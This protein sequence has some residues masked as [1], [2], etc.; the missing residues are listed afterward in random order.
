MAF[1]GDL[2]VRLG[3]DS[4]RFSRGVGKARSAIRSFSRFALNALAPIATVLGGRESVRAYEEQRTAIARLEQ[5]LKTTGNAAGVTSEQLQKFAAARQAVT[6]FGDEVTIQGASVLATFKNIQGQAF[7][8]TIEL[9]QDVSALMGNDLQSAMV[10][11][12]KAINDPIT[13]L[14]QLNRVGITFSKEQQE[15]IKLLQESGNLMEAQAVILDEVRS[16]FGGAAEAARSPWTALSNTFGDL[17]E[18]IGELISGGAG[19]SLVEWIDGVVQRVTQGVDVVI[20][21]RDAFYDWATTSAQN[22]NNV[23]AVILRGGQAV[24]E[25]VKKLFFGIVNFSMSWDVVK[26]AAVNFFHLAV[27]RFDW[28]TGVIGDFLGWFGRNWVQVF[29]TAIDFTLT[30][31][32]NLGENIRKIFSELW[33]VVASGFTKEFNVELNSLTEGFVNTIEE[34]FKIREFV[35]PEAK[36]DALDKF[37]AAF[38]EFEKMGKQS[39]E[40]TINPE[41]FKRTMGP[42]LGDIEREEQKQEPKKQGPTPAIGLNTKEGLETILNAMMGRSTPEDKTAKNTAS[43]DKTLKKIDRKLGTSPPVAG[44]TT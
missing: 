13:G 5:I 1:G 31:F 2:V 36:T 32:I 9:A 10:Q 29:E 11:L 25:M 17:L 34:K 23:F 6:N 38:S 8:D 35:A 18:K 20:Q 24:I 40:D 30:M 39:I 43:M 28:F 22:S 41:S 26:E 3:M 21:W 12:G 44:A 14:S 37:N 33:E 7:L 42:G 15:R 19:G 27:A 4:A 16:Q